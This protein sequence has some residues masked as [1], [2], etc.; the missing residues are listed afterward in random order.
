MATTPN[1]SGS[2]LKILK[3]IPVF[4]RLSPTQMQKLISLCASRKLADGDML[5][6]RGDASDEMFVILGGA[7]SLLRE[8][9]LEMARFEPV[10]S[11]GELGIVGDRP[12]RISARSVGNST[13]LVL[14]RKNFDRLLSDDMK[15]AVTVYRNLVLL[16]SER[17]DE[18]N[19]RALEH[20]EVCSRAKRLERELELTLEAMSK[21][22]IDSDE[23]RAGVEAHLRSVLP[24]ILIV[25]DE[26]EICSFLSRALAEYDVI[27]AKDGVSALELAGKRPPNLVITDINMPN[28]DGLELLA[29]LK[30]DQ[31]ELP[32]IGLSGYV[33]E[34]AVDGLGFDG[35]VF[36]PM[37]V[38]QLRST[39]KAH[40]EK[41]G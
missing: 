41:T 33:K 24:T 16:V 27:T 7:I 29:K 19:V 34:D 12:R 10:V 4:K 8:D 9:G 14:A 1:R 20:E 11:L 5:F 6:E 22:G 35:F 31:P 39:V 25:D 13:V 26:K 23:V 36:K 37:R 40:L 2:L 21:Q 17:I 38:A 3:R 18:D 30:H 32:V 28:M 15:M